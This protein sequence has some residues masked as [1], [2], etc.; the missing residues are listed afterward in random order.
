MAALF[1]ALLAAF[2]SGYFM[3]DLG[4]EQQSSLASAGE[5]NAVSVAD[6]SSK[7]QKSEAAK[8][9]KIVQLVQASQTNAYKNTVPVFINQSVQTAEQQPVITVQIQSAEQLLVTIES[10]SAQQKAPAEIRDSKEFQQLLSLLA[11]DPIARRDLLERFLK[12]SGTPLGDTLSLALAMS[13][14]GQEIPEIKAAAVQLLRS[15][16]AAQRL[17]ALQLLGQT[18][19]TEPGVRAMVLDILRHESNANPQLAMAAMATFSQKG[20][21]SQGEYQEVMGTI[22]PLLHSEDPQVRQSSLQV[23]S[24]WAGRDQAALQ[25]F[26]EATHDADP[27]VRSLAITTLGQGGFAYNSVRDTLLSALQN[28]DE[29]PIVK[30]ATQQALEGFPL[31]EQA[32]AI[33]QAHISNPMNQQTQVGFN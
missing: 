4:S 9:N 2:L 19:G 33:Y 18:N 10:L 8:Q 28:P 6:N 23:L 24:Q 14:G 30:A 5:A 31:D 3:R 17:N 1:T 20:V 29:A 11:T 27:G 26:T 16:T 15:G 25:T 22:V 32:L 13:G 7:T 12:V 21:V